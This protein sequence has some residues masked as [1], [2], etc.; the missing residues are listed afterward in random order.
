MSN[1]KQN[2][3]GQL[4]PYK[5]S[6]TWGN[7]G[8]GNELQSALENG[9]SWIGDKIINLDNYIEDAFNYG[10]IGIPAV[11]TGQFEKIKPFVDQKRNERTNSEIVQAVVPDLPILP[12]NA[13]K[14]A[15]SIYDKLKKA[16]SSWAV[17]ESQLK[18]L[19]QLDKLEG[20][21]TVTNYRKL[22]QQF[23]ESLI[24]QTHKKYLNENPLTRKGTSEFKS[25]KRFSMN[26][27]RA[28]NSGRPRVRE[29]QY[30]AVEEM[31]RKDPKAS[32][33][34]HRYDIK[35]AKGLDPSALR[36]ARMEMIQ[37]YLKVNPGY[38]TWLIK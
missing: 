9:L 38:F 12:K 22:E 6:G 35:V 27:G 37:Q 26:D 8:Q 10:I 11:L 33:L 31:M 21:K 17:R 32:G 20:T 16:R 3:R 14:T 25:N 34:L 30:D 28:T 36:K 24:P 19:G 23:Q 5:Y 2:Q 1:R 13:P 4:V 15:L 7:R 29:R 18:K